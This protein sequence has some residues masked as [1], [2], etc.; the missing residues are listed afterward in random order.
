MKIPFTNIQVGGS[1]QVE[2]LPRNSLGIPGSKLRS[3]TV[4][5]EEAKMIRDMTNLSS[6]LTRDMAELN[7]HMVR[8]YA[9]AL[10]DDYNK[11][12]KGTYGA[13]NSEILTS[14]Y[15]VRA[16]SRTLAKDTPHGKSIT[17]T[18]ANNVVGHDPFRLTM[19]L[20]K[21]VKKPSPKTGQEVS[22]FEPET[23]TNQLIE[24]EWRKFGRPENFTVRRTISRMEAFRQ[25]EME[26]ITIGS[27][28][29]RHHRDFPGN[30]YGYAVDLLES[31]R[32]MDNFMG[33]SKRNNPIRF[34]IEFDRRWNFPVYYWILTRHPGEYFQSNYTN[35]KGQDGTK[36]YREE[37][38]AADII[39]Y[40]NLRDRAEQDI[41]FTELDS[42]VRD[43]HHNFQ[44]ARALTLAS[45]ASCCKPFVVEKDF[46]TGLQYTP[47]PEEMGA[48]FQRNAGLDGTAGGAADELPR[49]QLDPVKLQ[50]G[51]IP[52]TQGMSPAMTQVMEWG[53][54]MK[55][56]DPKFPIEAAHEFRI[57]NL[58]DIAAGAGISYSAM[59]GDFQS[60][61]YIAA[62]MSK[63]PE[64]DNF[65]VRQ[66]NFVDV[67]VRPI[68][69][70]WLKAAIL[71]GI[72]D[73]DIRRLEEFVDAAYFK[74]KRWQFTDKLREVQAVILQE[75]AGHLSPQ[76]VQDQ[77]PDGID[78]ED[79]VAQRAEANALLE[80]HG[81]PTT[82]APTIVKEQEDVPDEPVPGQPAGSAETAPPP[83]KK[84]ANPLNGNG[85]AHGID[86]LTMALLSE[87]ELVPGSPPARR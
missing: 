19:R 61:G 48:M 59:S 1:S 22:V 75:N 30:D 54:K 5:P 11:D 84:T 87:T 58:K 56:L 14:Y 7:G 6:Q 40:N 36:I 50:Q 68:F 38:P 65:A 15:T 72:L 83:K 18:Y 41:G 34:S 29:I 9:A 77:M 37:V 28:L 35:P 16:R 52:P 21:Q 3:V 8:S 60:L 57:D 74:P 62:Q 45:V 4:R 47:T 25:A 27:I 23:E 51:N 85:K 53:F 44:Y 64:R 2:A 49:T 63:Q 17:R 13:P 78:Y 69:R 71:K 39:H 67:I 32:L 46:P 80:A 20:G 33:R 70:N 12:F 73:L 79:V 24:K 66:Q 42:I 76:Q 81:L 43:M 26:A 31:D 82:A 86:P 55:V 10:T